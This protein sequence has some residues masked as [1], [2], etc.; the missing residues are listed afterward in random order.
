MI[1]AN[2]PMMFFDTETAGLLPSHPI[3][4][5][6]ALAIKN[7]KPEREFEVKFRF[8]PHVADHKALAMNNYSKEDWAHAVNLAE[9]AKRFA[10]F[11]RPYI[12][13]RKVAESGT[14]YHV[15]RLYGYNCAA[16]DMPRVAKIY[17]DTRDTDNIFLP[18]DFRTRDV[19]QLVIWYYEFLG[20]PL[21]NSIKLDEICD[22]YNLGK[23]YK[24]HDALG[25]CYRTW[26]VYKFFM[27]KFHEDLRVQFPWSFQW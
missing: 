19:M 12:S 9:G 20:K 10:Q 26:E 7:G 15:A 24:S 6:G 17:E 4:Q 25:D 16:F 21:P 23:E 5:L 22:E 2:R 1:N 27:Q 18:A 8:D 11:L 3:I 13:E 14:I